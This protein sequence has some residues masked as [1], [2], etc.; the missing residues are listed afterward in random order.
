[1]CKYTHFEAK[2]FRMSNGQWERDILKTSV[3]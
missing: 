1:M 3:C 2:D